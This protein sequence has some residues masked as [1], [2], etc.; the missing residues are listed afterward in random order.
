M[1]EL[2]EVKSRGP[3]YS[4]LPLLLPINKFKLRALKLVAILLGR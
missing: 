2:V 4:T 3:P 1:Q